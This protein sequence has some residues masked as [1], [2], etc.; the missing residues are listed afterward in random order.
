MRDDIKKI[1]L[2]DPDNYN[3]LDIDLDDD[4]EDRRYY[5]YEWICNGKI[6]YVGKGTGKRYKHIVEEADLYE[7]N[8]KKYKGQRW[9]ILRAAYGI[10][11]NII[12]SDLTD[13]EALI[14]ETYYIVKYLK[15]R[16]PLFNHV[17]PELDEET[18]DY[19]NKVNYSKN[20][21][22]FFEEL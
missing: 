5:V 12:M 10:S 11:C 18:D 14:M 3:H 17:I 8:N 15:D 7:R 20:I 2:Q 1:Y 6:F 16:Q 21:L 13:T 22:E 19:W 9:S 4:S